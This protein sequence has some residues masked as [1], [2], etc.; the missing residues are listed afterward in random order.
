MNRFVKKLL[1][2]YVIYIEIIGYLLVILFIGGLIALSFIKAEDEY[3]NLNGHL[4][5][6]AELLVFEKEHYLIDVLSETNSS[7]NK[8]SPLLEITDDPKFITDRV[9][10][11]TME[12]QIEKVRQLSR[13]DLEDQLSAIIYDLEEKTYPN[14]R[15]NTIRTSISGDYI[16][17]QPE[18]DL[19]K[20][21]TAIGG[22]FDF[23]NAHIIVPQLPADRSQA[24]KLKAEQSGAATIL[25][26]A[27]NTRTV[28]VTLIRVAEDSA[29]ARIDEWTIVQKNEIARYF[30][31]LKND[32][33]ISVS[34]RI[35]VGWKSWMNLIWR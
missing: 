17:F 35:K 20:M 34:L 6:N 9:M 1:A 27:V 29:V 30:A 28:P 13:T 8:R 14:L 10:L 32:E 26:G 12:T 5:L 22:V 33:K 7:V 21:N 31:N 23:S 18:R 15:L 24:R 2:K 11:T 3:V 16:L 25:L 19:L 4:L